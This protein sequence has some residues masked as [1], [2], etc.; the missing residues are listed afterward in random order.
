MYVV[1]LGSTA[2]VSQPGFHMPVTC[3]PRDRRIGLVV[4]VCCCCCCSQIIVVGYHLPV[5]ER[6]HTTV[7]SMSCADSQP[8]A[9]EVSWLSESMLNESSVSRE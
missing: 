3:M 2:F 7:V 8:V 1:W 4:V 5:S 6:L 9:D